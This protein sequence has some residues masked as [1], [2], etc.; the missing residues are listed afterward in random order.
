MH[1]PG[2]NARPRSRPSGT[3]G[4]PDPGVAD[5]NDPLRELKVVREIPGKAPYEKG[6]RTRFTARTFLLIIRRIETGWAVTTA[7]QA[8]GF[9]YKRFR[10]I[11]RSATELPAPL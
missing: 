5:A 10:Q 11:C 6:T 3:H 2:A 7:C 4:K 1:D 8:E 9:T